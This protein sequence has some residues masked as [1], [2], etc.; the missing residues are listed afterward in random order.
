MIMK[1]KSIIKISEIRDGLLFYDFKVE[2]YPS[3][4]HHL[5][6]NKNKQIRA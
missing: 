6:N 3:F 5:S 2:P 4:W 1:L